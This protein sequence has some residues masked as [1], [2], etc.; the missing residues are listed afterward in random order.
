PHIQI[1]TSSAGRIFA[2]TYREAS[3]YNTDFRTFQLANKLTFNKG[4]HFFKLGLFAQLHD[5]DYGFLSAW[6]GRWEYRSVEDFLNDQPARVRG[7]YNINNK[8]FNFVNTQPSAT[9]GVFES[10]LYFQDKIRV[11]DRFEI[12]GGIRLD[13]QF[14]T[15]RIPLSD[16]IRNTGSFSKY[17]NQISKS[18][19][20][21]PRLSFNYKLD[22]QGNF[23]IR[24]G[25]GLFSGR[26]PYLWFAYAEYISGTE[27]FNIDIRPN[28]ALPLAENLETLRS[29]Q[30]N[31]AEINLLD[32]EFSLPRDWKS[33]IAFKAKL[34]NK[35]TL[36][37]EATYTDVIKG[38][39][40]Q[41]INRVNNTGN[42]S[43]ADSRPYFLATGEA[44]K[45]NPNLTN[46][47]LL[48]NTNLGYRYNLT[49][50]LKKQAGNYNGSFAYTYGKSK[51]V[52]STVRSSPAANFEWNQAIVGNQ[53]NLSFSN[54]DLRHKF[55]MNH[56]YQFKI[57]ECSSGFISFLYNGRAGSPF[58]YVYQG[59]LNQD[60]SS[61]ND[62]I[63]VPRD[64]SEINLID[65]VDGA[66]NIQ[67]SADEQ[68]QS[69]NQFIEKDPYLKN[70][71]GQTAE[72]NGPRTPWNHELDMKLEYSLQLKNQQRLSLSFDMLNVFNFI[73]PNWGR[74]V[75][76]PNVVN[77]SFSL[78]N[79]RGI[80]NN[81]AQFQFNIPEGT[82][83]YITDLFN[84][85][86]RG[87]LGLKYTF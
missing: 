63:Y 22:Q 3:V 64:A 6:N 23:S 40:F 76:V 26:I 79:F 62:L 66:G 31:L 77:S 58:S 42:F 71:R 33:N 20:I 21:N 65:I 30:P 37:L 12:M 81:E 85:R 61:R 83:P 55:V 11:N 75:F 8:D 41:S 44:I 38:L 43:G 51:D 5:V 78:L 50:G 10:A 32:P 15:Q 59:D 57:S 2:G 87:Q 29:L 25:S 45:V 86:W 56:S 48:T 39:L 24:G 67:I 49:L 16:E 53:P 9:I 28:E 17:N 69:L 14:L 60:G 27:Y 47:F 34:P 84:S 1:A 35:W 70:R 80:E 68:W 54:F 73:N 7:V 82:D 46:V 19:Q 13:G 4:K 18:P 72:R 74:L 36:E 52:S